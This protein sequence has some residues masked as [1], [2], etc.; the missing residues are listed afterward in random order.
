MVFLQIRR[1][2]AEVLY[3]SM[4]YNWSRTVVILPE[5][6]YVLVAKKLNYL[7]DMLAATTMSKEF[8]YDGLSQICTCGY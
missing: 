8:E 2:R 4:A 6:L 1:S 3:H 7:L 5:N